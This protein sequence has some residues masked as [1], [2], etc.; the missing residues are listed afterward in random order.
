MQVMY[1]HDLFITLVYGSHGIML[2]CFCSPLT[3]PKP[4]EI[5][6]LPL[7]TPGVLQS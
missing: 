6:R 4:L 7:R 3:Q 1:P 2:R 5:L